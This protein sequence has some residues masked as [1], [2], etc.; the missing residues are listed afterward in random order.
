MTT[1]ND[2]GYLAQTIWHE[3]GPLW[4]TDSTDVNNFVTQQAYIATALENRYDIA[5]GNI[6]AYTASGG[7]VNPGLFGGPGTSLTN[8]ILQAAGNN[9]S[10]GI[11]T[12]GTLDSMSTLKQ[13]L[14]T[15][16][17]V[18]PQV[19]LLP[20]SNFTVNSQ[21]FAA[22]S[23]ATEALLAQ[24]GARTEPSG[25]ILTYWN[26]ATNSSP[27]PRNT[28]TVPSFSLNGD[29]FYGYFTTQQPKPVRRPPP[30]RPGRPGRPG[31]L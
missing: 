12:N 11:Y 6:V 5:N 2:L 28:K 22:L 14:S 19:Q 15:D 24:G 18:G 30:R 8:V 10:W 31:P 17:S 1:Y 20:G 21:C 13:V 25:V 26:L 9:Q 7:T 3:G 16:I 4:K 23:A 29:T 27:D